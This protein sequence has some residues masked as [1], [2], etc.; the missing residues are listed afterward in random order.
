VVEA[1]IAA[2]GTAMTVRA[3]V[4]DDPDVERLFTETA[5]AFGGVDLVVH[6]TTGGTTHVD[7]HAASR[8]RRGG[9]IVQASS[10]DAITSALADDLHS[11][12]GTGN[13]LAR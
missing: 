3:D 13:G 2:N 11:R 8:L 12:D 6:A 1:I 5:A 4:T 9:A 10:V 7:R